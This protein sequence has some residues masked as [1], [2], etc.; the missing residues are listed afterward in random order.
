MIERAV[1][2]SGLIK[3]RGGRCKCLGGS[4]G[5]GRERL[6]D[7][8]RAIDQPTRGEAG[9]ASTRLDLV[10]GER[11]S[12]GILVISPNTAL[13]DFWLNHGASRRLEKWFRSIEDEDD[14]LRCVRVSRLFWALTGAH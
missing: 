7:M 5:S 6:A 3:R 14:A 1:R 2:C 11:S 9:D 10:F 4:G 8:K 12:R 13:D